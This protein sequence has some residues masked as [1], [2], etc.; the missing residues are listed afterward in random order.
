VYCRQL[1]GAIPS[2]PDEPE[3]NMAVACRGGF[4]DDVAQSVRRVLMWV[5]HVCYCYYTLLM[6]LRTARNMVP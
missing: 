4:A 6:L 5:A 1:A 3:I 2:Y